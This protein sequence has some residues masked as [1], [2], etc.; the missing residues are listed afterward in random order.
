MTIQLIQAHFVD[1]YDPTI[2]GIF[3][4]ATHTFP[5]TYRPW[6]LTTWSN[7]DS[8]RK[9]CNI[10]GEV[11]LLDVLDT[12]GQEEYSAMRE[13]YMRT[14]EGFLLVYSIT[15]R[16]S[17]E[18]IM[19]FQQQILRVKDKDYFPIILVGNK[20]DLEEERQVSQAGAFPALVQTGRTSILIPGCAEGES[21]ARKFGC[22]FIET[23]AK[24][25]INVDNAFYEIVREIR[26]YNRD[27]SSY[28]SGV[29]G[30][31]TSGPQ[32]KMELQRDEKEPGCCG[33]CSVM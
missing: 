30:Q 1:E 29:T 7:A 3:F 16:Q 27:M 18:E 26:R 28:P 20:C 21:V 23:S 32:S 31:S 24:S 33:S 8:Y 5:V 12:A 9:Q 19:M 15:S 13:Q 2:E 11:A 25:R 14:G 4:L 10:D 17:F 6:R 22:K